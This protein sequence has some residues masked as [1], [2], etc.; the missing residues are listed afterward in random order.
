[1]AAMVAFRQELACSPARAPEAAVRPSEALRWS[2]IRRVGRRT[3]YGLNPSVAWAGRE[4]ARMDDG[5][6]YHVHGHLRAGADGGL[7]GEMIEDPEQKIGQ[8]RQLYTG[9]PQRKYVL[10]DQRG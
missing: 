5:H 3:V 8:P 4:A 1:M 9:A 6:P 7:G 2:C 10:I